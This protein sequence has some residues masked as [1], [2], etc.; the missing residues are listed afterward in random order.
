[1]KKFNRQRLRNLLLSING[2]PMD[3]QKKERELSFSNWTG[4]QE[5]IDDVCLIGVSI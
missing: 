2:M 3:K 5:Q 4:N 1:V